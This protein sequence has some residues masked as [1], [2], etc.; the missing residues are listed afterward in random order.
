MPQVIHVLEVDARTPAIVLL[1]YSFTRANPNYGLEWSKDAMSWNSPPS[2]SQIF[3]TPL[4]QKVILRL[5]KANEDMVS[6]EF[7]RDHEKLW[8]EEGFQVSVLFP[9]GPL[10]FEAISHLNSSVGCVICGKKEASRCSQCQ[11]VTYCGSGA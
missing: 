10:P 8:T 11:S 1:Y 2:M 6:P 7:R 4:E 5:L 3:A 9:L